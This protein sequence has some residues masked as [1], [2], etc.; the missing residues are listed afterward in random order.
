MIYRLAAEL[1]ILV[2]FA[3]VAFVVVGALLVAYRPWVAFVHVPA[4]LW[5]A[6]TELLGIVCPLT[7]L[8]QRLW[9]LAGETGYAGDFLDHYLTLILYPTGLT[10]T[11]Q[12]GLGGALLV[13]NVV[14][15]GWTLARWRQRP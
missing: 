4:V 11:V 1:V 15:Y 7:P 2:H 5:G 9:R 12:V 10:R 3:F 13:L 14:L 6:A 8:E